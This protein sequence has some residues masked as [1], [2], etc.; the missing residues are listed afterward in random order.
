MN[1][2]N[3]EVPEE[4]QPEFKTEYFWAFMTMLLYHVGGVY[5]ISLEHL[6]QY[7]YEKDCP[8]VT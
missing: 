2:D 3:G 8:Q 5:T 4:Q 1:K 7:D 6:E